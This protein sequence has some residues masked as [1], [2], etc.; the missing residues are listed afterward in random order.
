MKAINHFKIPDDASDDISARRRAASCK[1]KTPLRLLAAE[2]AVLLLG[3]VL[4]IAVRMIPAER[5]APR[6][7]ES[8]RLNSAEMRPELLPQVEASSLDNYTDSLMLNVCLTESGDPIQDMLLAPFTAYGGDNAVEDFR[9]LCEGAEGGVQ[10]AYLRYW[11]GWQLFVRPPASLRQY[12]HH[13]LPADAVDAG[14]DSS[15]APAAA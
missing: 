4:L 5:I 3:P 11:H 1:V 9:L 10:T 6:A 14:A 7:V 8:S 13:T 12:L 2:L 15:A